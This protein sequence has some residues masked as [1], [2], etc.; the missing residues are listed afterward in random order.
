MMEGRTC[1]QL[2][3][4]RF[5]F[6][7]GL[8][9]RIKFSAPRSK[10]SRPAKRESLPTSINSVSGFDEKWPLLNGS[11]R[12]LATA[13]CLASPKPTDG[14]TRPLSPRRRHLGRLD[15]CKRFGQCGRH[16]LLQIVAPRGGRRR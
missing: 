4:E 5:C 1:G 9:N 13:P 16:R 15:G 12:I 3:T 2:G 6:A 7:C 11:R 10:M 8:R 14:P